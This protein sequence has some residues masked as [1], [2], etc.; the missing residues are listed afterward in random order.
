MHVVPQLQTVVN[1]LILLYKLVLWS[2]WSLL[3]SIVNRYTEMMATAIY[4]SYDTKRLR[5]WGLNW[6]TDNKIR[7]MTNLSKLRYQTI[8]ILRL[9][10]NNKIRHVTYFVKSFQV[11][12]LSRGKL[13]IKDLP[14]NFSLMSSFNY[15]LIDIFDV[16][17]VLLM[18]NFV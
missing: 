16:L 14:R 8:E 5:I 2:L 1:L 9:K 7:P 11:T 3:S 12:S 10:L 18:Q 13:F 6:Q 4:L 15:I 17:Q